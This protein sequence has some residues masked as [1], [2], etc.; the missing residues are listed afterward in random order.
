MA[1]SAR[2]PLAGAACAGRGPDLAAGRAGVA[3]AVVD[4][5]S[6]S[7]IVRVQEAVG[8]RRRRSS[9][10]NHPN[11]KAN[12]SS[13]LPGLGEAR[14]RAIRLPSAALA[15]TLF[16]GRDIGGC[17]GRNPERFQSGRLPVGGRGGIGEVR[18]RR[19]AGNRG[20]DAGPLEYGAGRCSGFGQ[21]CQGGQ[22]EQPAWGIN[23]SWRQRN[24]IGGT[25]TTDSDS[26]KVAL[27]GYEGTSYAATGQPAISGTARVGDTLTVDPG[28]IADDDGLP[29]FPDDFTF[30]WVRGSNDITGSA[31]ARRARPSATDSRWSPE[32]CRTGREGASGLALGWRWCG[33]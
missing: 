21:P 3:G 27:K 13:I 17:S 5:V 28:T 7:S 25:W 16:F 22:G 29:D 6:T 19:R 20:G 30:R 33:Y 18:V 26:P 15:G 14:G 24:T 11:R 9:P 23:N 10:G 1:R 2:S 32:R 31:I 12:I 8:R 4:G